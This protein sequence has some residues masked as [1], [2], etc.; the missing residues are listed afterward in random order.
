MH[1]SSIAT[2]LR[3]ID[4]DEPLFP[5]VKKTCPRQISK[6]FRFGGVAFAAL[7]IRLWREQLK[8]LRFKP[9]PSRN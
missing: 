6:G 1:N 9:M 8:Q 5:R 7:N 3:W 2:F 4:S